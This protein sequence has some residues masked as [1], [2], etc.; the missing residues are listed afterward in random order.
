MFTNLW[1]LSH[2]PVSKSGS[3]LPFYFKKNLEKGERLDLFSN[4]QMDLEVQ[5]NLGLLMLSEVEVVVNHVF[6]KRPMYGCSI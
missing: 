6:L 4:Q 3:Y 2:S 5:K 1:G